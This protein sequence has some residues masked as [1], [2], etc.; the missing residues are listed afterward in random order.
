MSPDEDKMD[1]LRFTQ[2]VILT[3]AA[4]KPGDDNSNPNPNFA[5]C[6]LLLLYRVEMKEAK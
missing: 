5:D 2:G 3:L 1:N 4:L 6:S